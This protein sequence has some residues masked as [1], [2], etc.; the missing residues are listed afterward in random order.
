MN[1]SPMPI[2]RTLGP[3]L[4]DEMT[5]TEVAGRMGYHPNTVRQQCKDGIL[6]YDQTGPRRR[7]RFSRDVMRRRFPNTDWDGP[8]GR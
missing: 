7:I 5:V 3:T 2:A 8:Y 1:D 6:P 4:S